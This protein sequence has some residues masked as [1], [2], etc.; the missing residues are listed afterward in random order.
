MEQY[1]IVRVVYSNDAAGVEVLDAVE[2]RPPQTQ[3][4]IKRISSVETKVLNEVLEEAFTQHGLIHPAVCKILKV[5]LH[6]R[7]VF[8]VLEKLVC[9]LARLIKDKL[10]SQTVFSEDEVMSFLRQ[11]V[12][13][14]AFAQDKVRGS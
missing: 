7:G 8:I 4:I 9:D 11:M 1:S 3:V 12:D 2:V 5:G 6:S 13:V 14:L 10:I